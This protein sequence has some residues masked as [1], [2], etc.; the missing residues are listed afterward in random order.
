MAEGLWNP[1]FLAFA[2]DGTLYVTE[3]GIGGDEP[4][5]FGPPPGEA[6]PVAEP[7]VEGTPAAEEAVEGGSTRGYTG[8][9]SAIAP[10]GTVTV[11]VSGLPSYS[12]GVGP[13]GITLQDGI[14]YFT[15]G[16]T[17]VLAGVEPLE[18]ENNVFSF[19][20]T[21]G[22][23]TPIA[24]FNIPEV[25]DNPDGTDVNPN[26][27][28]IAAGRS[29]GRLTVVDAGGNTVYSLDVATGDIQLRAVVPTLDVLMPR[30]WLRSSAAGSNRRRLSQRWCPGFPA[31]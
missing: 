22:T 7:V 20:P 16:G 9:I 30:C 17:A 12:D 8:Q 14:V 28:G 15:V 27:Y 4:F 19:D 31:Q 26:L 5:V 1:R 25:E 6:S 11:P 3:V 24:D 29:D 2:D 18:G 13:H 10:D 23:V 21:T